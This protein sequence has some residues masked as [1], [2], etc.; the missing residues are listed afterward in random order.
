MLNPDLRN[1]SLGRSL[2]KDEAAFAVALEAIFASGAHAAPVVALA[3]QERRVK[4]PSGG[5]AAWDEAALLQE[6]ADLNATLD[7]SYLSNGIGS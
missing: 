2:T 6:L 3:L 5:V 1:Q 4:R 7:A